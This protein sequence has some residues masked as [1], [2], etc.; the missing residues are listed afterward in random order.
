MLEAAIKA[1]VDL[2]NNANRLKAYRPDAEPR[3]VYLLEQRDG[4]FI[5]R[6]AAPRPRY[7]VVHD[8]DSFAERVQT[9]AP[10]KGKS[11][12]YI[13]PERVCAVLDDTGSRRDRI[14]LPLLPN[15]PQFDAVKVASREDLR[16]QAQFVDLLR[17]DL[18]TAVDAD[19]ITLFRSLKGSRSSETRS[20]VQVGKESMGRDV[21]AEV[22][23]SGKDIPDTIIVTTPVYDLP[24]FPTAKIK[25]AV[26]CDLM[27]M[28]FGL[29]PLAGEIRKAE[30]IAQRT[31]AVQ[32]GSALS[33]Y[34][35]VLGE[36]TEV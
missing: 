19:T 33:G 26:I 29:R 16:N 13:S 34:S 30:I 23:A 2:A 9:L 3:H 14:D 18:A 17:I 1:I 24:D 6:E 8:V 7:D 4:T 12:I 20:S 32:G 25:C 35:V 22:A 10:E 36:P 5:S 21:H 27:E 15:T 28:K 31:I 11:V